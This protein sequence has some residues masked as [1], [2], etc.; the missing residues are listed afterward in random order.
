MKIAAILLTCASFAGLGAMPAAAST[1]QMFAGCDGL[2]KPKGNDSGMRGVATINSY[3]SLRF[4]DTPARTIDYCSR[5]LDSDKLK[6]KQN[7]RRAH[8][9]RARAAAYLETGDID[10]ALADLD[11]AEQASAAYAGQFFFDRSMGLSLGLLRAIALSESGAHDAAMQLVADAAAARPYALR[12]QSAAFMISVAAQAPDEQRTS[13]LSAL[14]LIEPD[15]RVIFATNVEDG[16]GL[17][18]AA[19]ESLDQ[20]LELPGPFRLNLQAFNPQFNVEAAVANW[21]S[22]YVPATRIAYGHAISGELEQATTRMDEIRA[23]ARPVDDS[24]SQAALQNQLADLLDNSV[25][26]PTQLMIDAR[27]AIGEGR[28]AEAFTLLADKEWTTSAI[29][30]E[31]YAAY[32]AGSKASEVPWENLPEL[33]QPS[34]ALNRSLTEIADDLLFYPETER[35]LIAYKESRPNILAGLVGGALTMGIGLFDGIPRTEG[36]E[37]TENADGTVTVTYI[38]SSN[39]AA[40]VQ[41]MTLL[42]AA[43]LAA[44]AQAT[45]F[46]IEDRTDYQQFRIMSQYGMEQSRTPSGYKTELIVRFVDDIDAAPHAIDAVS[47]IDQLGAIYYRQ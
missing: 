6:P 30:S 46:Q 37:Q 14:A 19:Q 26:V 42:R 32:A 13:L 21:L 9:L 4:N 40:V 10:A 23:S 7:L 25:L 33:M 11:A 1:S 27:L 43:E 34:R 22:S 31:L 47:L 20:P 36:F 12:A 29:T 2:K 17:A 16:A 3:S 44:G 45:A 8:V 41:E 24:T 28:G 39:S 35:D 15:S 38:G 5:V 18:A